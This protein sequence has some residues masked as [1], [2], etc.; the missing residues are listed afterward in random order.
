M[1]SRLDADSV[2]V[3]VFEDTTGLKPGSLVHASGLP[4]AAEL[5]PGMLGCMFD[6]IQ[7]PLSSIAQIAGDFFDAGVNVTALD[8]EHRWQFEPSLESGTQVNEGQTLGLVPE[9]ADMSHR[10][11]I[12]PGVNGTLEWI[13]DAG[14]YVIE[15]TVARV[16]TGNGLS[17]VAMLRRWP[18]RKTRPSARRLSLEAP[19]LTGQRAIDTFFPIAKGGAA[20]LPGGFGTGKTVLLQTVAKWCIS[21][22]ASAAM[23]WPMCWTNFRNSKTRAAGANSWSAPC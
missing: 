20:S 22:A 11:L 10:V 5:G 14:E 18:I 21:G 13:A 2:T 8:R 12:P 23:K 1:L 16:R 6:G 3:Q 17:D 19:L 4:L 9:S 15:D 7:R